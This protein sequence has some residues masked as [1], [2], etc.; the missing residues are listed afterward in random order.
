MNPFR[1]KQQQKITQTADQRMSFEMLKEEHK[2]QPEKVH[3]QLATETNFLF[4]PQCAIELA[5][6][7]EE[8]IITETG[9]T[10]PTQKQSKAFQIIEIGHELRTKATHKGLAKNTKFDFCPYCATKLEK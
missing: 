8:Q 4:C 3:S 2:T 7:P 1:R 10:K 6:I 9:Y 5:T